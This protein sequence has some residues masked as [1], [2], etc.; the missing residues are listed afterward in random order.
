[1]EF[2]ELLPF[3]IDLEI[4]PGDFVIEEGLKTVLA[5]YLTSGQ[6]SV[7]VLKIVLEALESLPP[8][9]RYLVRSRHVY[10]ARAVITGSTSNTAVQG[11]VFASLGNQTALDA[12]LTNNSAV[13]IGKNT[14]IT[15]VATFASHVPS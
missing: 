14:T 3:Q 7:T 13:I 2:I 12:T 15:A 4:D 10:G 11:D 5:D 9:G 6:I 8:A 1:M